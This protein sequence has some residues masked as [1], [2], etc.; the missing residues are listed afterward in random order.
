[1]KSFIYFAQT[2]IYISA[3]NPAMLNILSRKR[4]HITKIA[5]LGIVGLVM[6]IGMASVDTIWSLYLFSFLKSEVK[7]G[8]LA[9]FFTAISFFSS[10]A[11]IPFI[12]RM[13]ESV[14]YKWI[15]FINGMVYFAFAIN[16]SFII[17][18]VLAIINVVILNA[19][20]T[21]FGILV[22]NESRLKD[23]GKDESLV[24]TL[25]NIGWL[26]G[27]LIA[28]FAA[29]RFSINF[30]F[31]LASIF[32]MLSFLMTLQIKLKRSRIVRENHKNLIKNFKAYFKNWKRV[33]AYIV[34]SGVAFWW[35]FIYIFMPLEIIK[36]G[37]SPSFVGLFL[38]LIVVPL[39]LF[40]YVAGKL[41]DRHGFRIFFICGFLA[42]SLLSGMLF[43]MDNILMIAI[44]LVIGSFAIAFIEPLQESYF[45]ACI[46]KKDEEVYYPTFL[47]S[48]PIALTL[49]RVMIA[50]ILLQLSFNHI[51]IMMS[52]VMLALVFVV[53]NIKEPLLNRTFK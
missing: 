20:I 39:I 9:A 13:D 38:F 25:L 32:V 1:M 18:I 8:F 14:M 37:L 34:S 6:T 10:I 44:Y 51:F 27:P 17:L 15:I 5:N 4:K 24:Y 31:L 36:R 50:L 33:S 52:L 40:E 28:G 19:R 42:L 53:L 21:T 22:R 12:E 35:S 45:F 46:K 11:L 16:R 2:F 30:V 3:N 43:F 47:T 23:L 48:K 49:S 41:A 29:D 26:V 7:V